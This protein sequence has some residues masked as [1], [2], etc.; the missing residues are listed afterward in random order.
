MKQ[1]K[2]NPT[3][4]VDSKFLTCSFCSEVNPTTRPTN[5]YFVTLLYRVVKVVEV[6]RVWKSESCCF[7]FQPSR[8]STQ[9]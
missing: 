1:M 4:R 6:E 3:T 9:V 2:E 8:N 7:A 5:Y